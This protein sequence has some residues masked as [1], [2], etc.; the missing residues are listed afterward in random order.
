MLATRTASIVSAARHYATGSGS[1]NVTQPELDVETALAITQMTISQLS[2]KKM[3]FSKQLEAI[4]NTEA[5]MHEK[6]QMMIQ[7]FI[8]AQLHAIIP[9]GFTPD[10]NGLKAFM[11]G[12]ETVSR[13]AEGKEVLELSKKRWA[14]LV[15]EAF[16]VTFTEQDKLPLE[17]ARHMTAILGMKMQSEDFLKRVDAA[18]KPLGANASNI[19]KQR[20]LLSLIVDL[21]TEVASEFGFKG[22]DGYVKFQCNMHEYAGDDSITYNMMAG[23]MTVFRRAGISMG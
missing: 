12:F 4:R 21:N 18:I 11:M 2:N 13:S 19:D 22:N 20:T 8:S 6:W 23:T 17:K 9:F 7:V 16:G 3:T 15:K 5:P 10:D 1:N 14:I